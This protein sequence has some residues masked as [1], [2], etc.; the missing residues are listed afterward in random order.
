MLIRREGNNR[1]LA[2]RAKYEFRTDVQQTHRAMD[3]GYCAPGAA[4]VQD[5]GV[6]MYILVCCDS[7]PYVCEVVLVSV[8]V[9]QIKLSEILFI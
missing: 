4:C 9:Q 1:G 8:S 7:K 2:W 3:Q 5:Y 6:C